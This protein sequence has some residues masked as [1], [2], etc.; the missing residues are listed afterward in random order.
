MEIIGSDEFEN[1]NL[2]AAR[3][4]VILA[5]NDENFL[6][7]DKNTQKKILITGPSGNLVKILNG[8]WSYTWQGENEENFL[9]FGRQ[10]RK[11]IFE[12]VKDKM[13]IKNNV[14][15]VKGVDFKEKVNFDEAINE[16]KVA[17]LI[18]L[19]IGEDTYTETPGNIG[20]LLLNHEQYELANEIFKLKKQVVVIYVGGRPRIITNIDKYASATLISFLPGKF[21]NS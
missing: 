12:A 3:E 16:A 6:P 15:Y 2:E 5:K 4:S 14:K 13:N 21:F 10:K 9:S 19:T 20:S 11:T 8:G 17:D 18:L 1:I 7:L